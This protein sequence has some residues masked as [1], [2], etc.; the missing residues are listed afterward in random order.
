MLFTVYYVLG[1][2]GTPPTLQLR[3]IGSSSGHALCREASVHILGGT[4]CHRAN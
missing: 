4:I 3:L 2:A 1:L